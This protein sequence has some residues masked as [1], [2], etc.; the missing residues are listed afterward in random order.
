MIRVQSSDPGGDPKR[1]VLIYC[2]TIRSESDRKISYGYYNQ[3]GVF[4]LKD[5]EQNQP[6]AFCNWG[7]GV[8]W[9]DP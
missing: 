5:E 1:S 3:R 6:N 7:Y 8:K 4:R 2:R 9:E